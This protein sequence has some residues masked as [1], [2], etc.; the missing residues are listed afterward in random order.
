[1]G[2]ATAKT[3]LALESPEDR[4]AEMALLTPGEQL[5]IA[6]EVTRALRLR[7]LSQS[8]RRVVQWR[9]RERLRLAAARQLELLGSR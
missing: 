8:E 9:V 3:A 6:R 4:G 1:M 5:A 2:I 7:R